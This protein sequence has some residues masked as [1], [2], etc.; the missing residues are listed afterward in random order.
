M[1]ILIMSIFVAALICC[2]CS[3]RVEVRIIT[4]YNVEDANDGCVAKEIHTT[5]ECLETKKR[6]TWRGD[7]GKEGDK[8]TA[9]KAF[10]GE[11]YP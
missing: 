7:Y 8:F 9:T 6:A 5:I 11:I 10:D 3:R 4:H 1:K 2:G